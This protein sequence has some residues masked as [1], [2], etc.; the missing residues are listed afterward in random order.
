MALWF[1]KTEIDTKDSG[2]EG[3]ETALEFWP[4]KQGMCTQVT[5]KMAKRMDKDE[6]T[7]NV[8]MST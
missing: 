2:S 6:K 3:F 8:A 4:T 5:L 7:L 1:M